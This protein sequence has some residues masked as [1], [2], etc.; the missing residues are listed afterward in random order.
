MD[1]FREVVVKS[2][3][4]EKNPVDKTRDKRGGPVQD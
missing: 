1:S 3:E 4:S 2:V